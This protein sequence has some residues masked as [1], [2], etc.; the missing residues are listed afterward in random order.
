[1]R[2]MIHGVEHVAIASPDPDALASWYVS[3]LGYAIE[4]HSPASRNYFLKA[5][6][7]SR[8]EIILAETP[9]RTVEM[10][11]A[12][13]RHLAIITDEFDQDYADL[14]SGGVVLLTEPETRS[15]NRVVFFRDPDGNVLHLIQRSAPLTLG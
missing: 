12:G 15:G 5:K 10:R 7:G 13:I 9:L 2:V 11:D 8:L 14:K 4:S 6:N 1:M 3:K